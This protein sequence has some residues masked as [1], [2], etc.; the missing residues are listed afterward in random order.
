MLTKT[1]LQAIDKLFSKRV[2][3]EIEAEGRNIREELRSDII[4]TRVRIQQDIRELADRTKN[5]EI[6][7]NGSEKKLEDLGKE[8]KQGFRKLNKR[9]TDL[10]DFLDKDL[11]KTAKKVKRIEEHLHIEPTS[12]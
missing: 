12:P 3:E 1:D 2:R 10:F 8:T 4:E 6:R 11:M 9:F 7:T 5:L